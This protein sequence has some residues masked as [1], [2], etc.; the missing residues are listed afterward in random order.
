MQMQDLY[1]CIEIILEHFQN[2]KLAKWV[3]L[4]TLGKDL[5][6]VEIFEK[7]DLRINSCVFI[8]SRRLR[9]TGIFL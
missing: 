9:F 5:K 6:F 8:C 7:N 4:G 1:K 2:L 3:L